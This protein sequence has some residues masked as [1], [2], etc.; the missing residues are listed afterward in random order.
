MLIMVFIWKYAYVCSTLVLVRLQNSSHPAQSLIIPGFSVSAHG[1]L[2]K[3]EK[4]YENITKH[5]YILN[6]FIAIIQ[7]IL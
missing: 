6:V 1:V 5:V 7:K 4:L 3:S 2:Y